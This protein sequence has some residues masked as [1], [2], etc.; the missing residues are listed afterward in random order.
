MAISMTRPEAVRIAGL[1]TAIRFA[2][3]P[4]VAGLL[5]LAAALPG[6]ATPTRAAALALF[7]VAALTDLAD[8]FIARRFDGVTPLGAALD[9]AADKALTSATLI[10]LAAT[11]FPPYL[12]AVAMLLI[13]RD[14]AVAGLREGL[15]LSGKALPVDATGKWKTGLLMAGLTAALLE[16]ALLAFPLSGVADA[17]YVLTHIGL[18]GA[19]C[20]AL[21]SA[22]LYVMRATQAGDAPPR[23]DRHQGA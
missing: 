19:L 18:L 10:G 5:L 20:L 14:I 21:W 4:A 3:A 15:A 13:V 11:L 17:A 8:G 6:I 12:A 9:H 1:L 23:Q 16:A 7:V 2:A 22:G